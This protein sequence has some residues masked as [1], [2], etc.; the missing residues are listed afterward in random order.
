VPLVP[1]PDHWFE[2]VTKPGWQGPAQPY[3]SSWTQP[4]KKSKKLNQ[5]ISKKFVIFPY[6]FLINFAQYWFVFLYCKDTNL[7]LKYLVFV[8]T[9]IKKIKCFVFMHTAKSLKNKNKIILYFHTTKT[10]SKNM[11]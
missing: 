7:I 4:Q 8:K 6:I 3:G 9:K 11:Y 2:P 5:K 10:I 1:Q